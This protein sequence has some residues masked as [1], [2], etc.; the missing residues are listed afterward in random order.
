MVNPIP[1]PGHFVFAVQETAFH[2]NDLRP[3]HECAGDRI[4]VI[5]LGEASH[6]GPQR[7]SNIVLLRARRHQR[8]IAALV[9]KN[10]A[11]ITRH[12]GSRAAALG[13]NLSYRTMAGQPPIDAP[14]ERTM[15]ARDAESEA[16][17]VPANSTSS[18]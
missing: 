14:A 9:Q 10:K 6:P 13:S 15:P 18:Y 4:T 7:R 1:E 17:A 8:V 12:L 16:S 5:G 2:L 11:E 3:T